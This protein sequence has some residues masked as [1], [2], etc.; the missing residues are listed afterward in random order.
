MLL[1]SLL[2]SIS[3]CV[4]GGGKSGRASIKDF[5]LGGET[6]TGPCTAFYRPNDQTCLDACPTGTREGTVQ[7]VSDAVDQVNGDD[8]LGDVLKASILADID[9]AARV[10]LEG[11]GVLRPSD[12]TVNKDF[13]ACEG[14][15]AIIL[16]NCDA[17]CAGQNDESPTLHGSVK[18]GE[19]SLFNSDLGN[20]DNWC[21]KE[22]TNSDFKSPACRLEYFDGAGTVTTPITV[23]AGS[24]VFTANIASIPKK[25]PLVVRVVEFQSGSAAQSSAFQI[26]RIDPVDT[27]QVP[28]GPLKIM[29]A[30]QYTCLTRAGTQE[31]TGNI[32]DNAARLHFYFPTNNDPPA[33]PPGNPFLICHDTNLNPGD[34]SPLFPRLELVPQHFSVWDISDLRFADQD[35]DGSS[36][37]NKSIQDK[38]LNDFNDTRE[39]NLFNI[40]QW[41][42][43]P[44]SDTTPPTVG[45][46]MQP[47]INGLTGRGFCPTQSD[48]NGNDNLFKV[49]KELVGV[50]TEGIYLAVREPVRLTDDTGTVV[51][52]PDDIL[53]I[54]ENLLEKIWFYSENNQLFIP[55]EITSGS[56]TIHFY[57]PA[58]TDDPLVRKST[59][60]IY[61]VRA[62]ENLNADSQSA[63]GIPT[64]I[65]PP[66]K[67]FG[68]V[69]A[70]D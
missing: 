39:I 19:N 54:R 53:I 55:D 13:C 47:F 68:C 65:R 57:W 56:K 12:I 40:F 22:I 25:T 2:A 70:L 18:L 64:V 33:Q 16:N 42:N 35:G 66:D 37:V 7:E 6:A 9:S 69:P 27:S 46:F 43:R 44:S 21:N 59:Q 23:N 11:S 26:Y 31:P 50:D 49:L 10:C 20:L 1:M 67:R 24:N 45:M 52:A 60:K 63:T 38:L 28:T 62:P 48:Y 51:T 58:D 32:F 4:D 34:D 61:T 5:T 3:S 8:S 30:S 41:P 36:D 15:K 29:P 14:N 17:F